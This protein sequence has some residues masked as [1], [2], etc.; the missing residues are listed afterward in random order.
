MRKNGPS[1]KTFRKAGYSGKNSAAKPTKKIKETL[2]FYRP[3]E[4]MLKEG[5]EALSNLELVVAVLGVG[6]KGKD[7]YQLAWE[8]LKLTEKDFNG[9]T[10][11]KLKDIGGVGNARAC[12]II[13][14]FELSKRFLPREEIKIKTDKDA[15][16]L[17]A[18]IAENKKE[19]FLSLTLDGAN[20]LIRKRTV[21]IGTVNQSLVHPREIFTDAV[22]DRAVGIILAHNHP[23]G[24]HSP[25]KEDYAVTDQLIKAGK[26]MGIDVVDHLILSKSGYYSFQRSGYFRRPPGT[27]KM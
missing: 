1:G 25:S 23:S 18:E 17:V 16:P 24:D 19:Y 27:F 15:F 7:V 3:R 4:K 14:S 10:V 22:A 26:I 12:Q 21:F 2:P 9:L 20:N 6:V 13:A 5:P 8:I 11:E